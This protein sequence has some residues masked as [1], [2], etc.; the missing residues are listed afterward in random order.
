MQQSIASL[1]E[2]YLARSDL[3]PAS[4][5]FKKQALR[6]FVEWFGDLP[7]GEITPA[8]AED[9][10]TLLAKGR[11]K[12]AANG[13]LANFR[14]F[15]GWLF[16]HGR[17]KSNPFDGIDAYK[18]TERNRDTFSPNDLSR[19]LSV[20]DDL[21]RMRIC[22]GLLGCRR[23]EMLNVTVRDIFLDAAEPHILLSPK[24][25]GGNTWAWDLKNHSVRYIG[26][27]PVMQ[28]PGIAVEL[29]KLIV[30]RIEELPNDQP[31]VFMETKYFRKHIGKD[32]IPDPTGNFQRM[33]RTVQKRAQIQP[34][35]RYHELRAAFA[36]AMITD[37]GLSRAADL[38]G[39]ASTQTT[40]KYDRKSM[41]S[42][43]ANVNRVASNCYASK[44]P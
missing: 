22:L 4:I 32:W 35:R 17:I 7:V 38:L 3:R 16:R 39:H 2:L 25:A 31:Y 28:F 14:P 12:C 8:I 19:L 13:Y 27:P 1:F 6:Y 20:S 44:V 29:H 21:W 33:F 5:R 23:G 10:R 9:Y 37:V 43:V 26:L 41:M 34:I 18:L 15:F 36:T 42:L 30:R 11:S 40:R 24:K